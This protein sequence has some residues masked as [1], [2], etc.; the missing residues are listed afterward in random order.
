MTRNEIVYNVS[1]V[2]NLIYVWQCWRISFLKILAFIITIRVSLLSCVTL[3]LKTESSTMETTAASS[4]SAL[5]EPL[6]I[7][8]SYQ[9]NHLNITASELLQQEQ[10]RGHADKTLQRGLEIAA[11]WVA[12]DFV[13]SQ[14]Q[15]Q[16]SSQS[17]PHRE[18]TITNTRQKQRQSQQSRRQMLYTDFEKYPSTVT[19]VVDMMNMLCKS[20]SYTCLLVTQRVCVVWQPSLD[21]SSK[22]QIQTGL[23]NALKDSI[24]TG[25]L[26]DN[27][28][29]DYL[30]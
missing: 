30:P 4:S 11:S 26:I 7:N 25:H 28:P 16:Q 1:M 12:Q 6:C 21:T 20:T 5:D 27:I 10:R 29:P 14:D 13:Q 9:I 8:V 2:V 17:S 24:N 23:R 22:A 3:S 19:G 18:L 15:Q